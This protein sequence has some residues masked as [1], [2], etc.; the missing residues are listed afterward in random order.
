M[1]F[2]PIIHKVRKRMRAGFWCPSKI[3]LLCVF[4]FYLLI[5]YF[6]SIDTCNSSIFYICYLYI[7]YL[8][9]YLLT[10]ILLTPIVPRS[11][12]VLYALTGISNGIIVNDVPLYSPLLIV[13]SN[14]Y[15]LLVPSGT[16]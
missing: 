13:P 2:V 7:V 16:A 4:I 14:E 5:I 10:F 12:L 11:L 8:L 3:Y 1:T 6:T 15:S 9:F